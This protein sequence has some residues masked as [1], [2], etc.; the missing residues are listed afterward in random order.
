MLL[1]SVFAA[2]ALTLAAVGIYGILTFMVTHRRREIGIRLALGARPAE[3][4]RM[5][6]R[7]GL[8][9]TLIGCVLGAAGAWAAGRS[10]AGFLYGV[11]PWE[12]AT[13]AAVF[14]SVL[15]VALV[16]CLVPGRRAS[17]EDPVEALRVE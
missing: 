14:A 1:M 2:L 13:V 16:A 10:L 11:A 17:A 15:A 7:E 12:P 4:L 3:V 9:L 8:G 6:V 5:I